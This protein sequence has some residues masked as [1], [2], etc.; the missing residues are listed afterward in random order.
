[1]WGADPPRIHSASLV[2]QV[3]R[4]SDVWV[5]QLLMLDSNK[6]NTTTIE[7]TV[8]DRNDRIQ[9]PRMAGH[10]VYDWHRKAQVLH[11]TTPSYSQTSQNQ[12]KVTQS[13][14][15]LNLE[16]AW[17]F[18]TPSPPKKNFQF[19][20]PKT[21]PLHNHW[22]GLTPLPTPRVRICYEYRRCSPLFRIYAPM[23][24]SYYSRLR[25]CWTS[26]PHAVLPPPDN[27]MLP[28]IYPF[29]TPS[30]RTHVKLR[31]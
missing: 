24:L 16:R 4:T 31:V 9:R 25:A 1:M 6:L 26:P 28:V 12:R 11:H 14:F 19:H 13:S 2:R 29:I 22:R 27:N 30:D 8:L 18:E 7:T 20:G 21:P 3:P 5:L 17:T 10:Q 23:S 15:P